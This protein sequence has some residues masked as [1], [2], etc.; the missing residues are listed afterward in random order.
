MTKTF[1]LVKYLYEADNAEKE[2][3]LDSE[4][5]QEESSKKYVPRSAVEQPPADYQ[6]AGGQLPMQD[7]NA[8]GM[9]AGVDPMT[10]L[11][12]EPPMEPEEIGKV[13]MLLK[14]HSRLEAICRLLDDLSD[15][16]Y[17]DIKQSVGETLELFKTIVVNFDSFKQTPDGKEGKLDLIIDRYKEF[18]KNIADKLK[19]LGDK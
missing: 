15:E 13:Y 11:P 4:K 2:I 16:K 1:K 17:N 5:D 6:G 10:G 7:P 9:G 14:I 18:I 8:L 19:N 3:P 12:V